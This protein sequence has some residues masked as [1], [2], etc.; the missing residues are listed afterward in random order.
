MAWNI[1]LSRLARKHLKNLPPHVTRRILKFLH[2]RVAPL[3]SPRQ[4]GDALT[5]AILGD[6]WRYPVGDY[7][8]I[9]LIEDHVL[10]VVIVRIGH[11]RDV[12]KP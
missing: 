3:D 6:Y 1:E 9:A 5:G 11:R 2:E 10:N 8:V 12:Y 4:I 7:R